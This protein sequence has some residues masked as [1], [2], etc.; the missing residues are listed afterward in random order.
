MVVSGPPPASSQGRTEIT[1]KFNEG[2]SR[3]ASCS[4]TVVVLADFDDPDVARLTELDGHL[5]HIPL[6]LPSEDYN[7]AGD[8][9]HGW[10]LSVGP[11]VLTSDHLS[12]AS[13]VV[14]R[15]WR[16]SPPSPIVTVT[17]LTD[18]D[19]RRFAER[20]WNAALL[21]LLH[22]EYLKRPQRW[23]RD[24]LAADN[25][26]ATLTALADHVRVPA[27]STSSRKPQVAQR[28]VWK[29]IDI[30]QSCGPGRASTIEVTGDLDVRQ[31]CPGFY[32]DVI[33]SSYE[34]RVG[35]VFGE[36]TLIAQY[37][38]ETIGTHIDRRY[39]DHHRTALSDARLAESAVV[40]SRELRLNVFTADVLVD[41]EGVAWWCDVNPDGLF[42]AA[43]TEHGDLVRTLTA[44]LH[45]G[46]TSAISKIEA[47]ANA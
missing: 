3:M 12:T 37:P 17:S 47:E 34:V 2:W 21:G 18:L 14:F 10:Q 45:S 29:P 6:A 46:Q 4:E 7:L 28:Q 25:K 43:D 8:L 38:T 13:N 31:P 15:R 16:G 32:Q 33:D 26:I 41:G 11:H 44:A 24:P 20:Q 5:C 42:C 22:S 9:I 30:D 35:F 23:S 40:V 1:A 36:I 19:H 39:I 27:T